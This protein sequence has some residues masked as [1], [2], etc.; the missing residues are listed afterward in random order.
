MTATCGGIGSA[1][2]VR[3]LDHPAG[4]VGVSGVMRM[5]VSTDGK[6]Q[7]IPAIVTSHT[8]ASTGCEHSNEGQW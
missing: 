5:P 4:I 7:F 2:V 3:V 8:R 1:K 6:Q